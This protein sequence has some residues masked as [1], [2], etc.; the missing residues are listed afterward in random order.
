[1]LRYDEDGYGDA[2]DRAVMEALTEVQRE[3][4]LAKRYELRENAK[5]IWETKKKNR[6]EAKRVSPVL[7]CSVLAS[8]LLPN[9]PTF[10]GSLHLKRCAGVTSIDRRGA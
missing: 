6:E 5:A 9:V 7:S 2:E 1:M 10:T 4:E 3:S 8:R